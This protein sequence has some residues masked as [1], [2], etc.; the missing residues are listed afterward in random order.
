MSKGS[1]GQPP[2]A[3]GDRAVGPGS[4][5]VSC[6]AAHTFHRP[7]RP[8]GLRQPFAPS[9]SGSQREGTWSCGWSRATAAQRLGWAT[10]P[11]SSLF[12]G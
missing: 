5:L 7:P 11:G 2:T 12:F 6:L 9:G 1:P 4:G 3:P 8:M 10:H